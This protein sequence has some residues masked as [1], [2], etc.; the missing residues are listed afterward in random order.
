MGIYKKVPY[1]VGAVSGVYAP[2]RLKDKVIPIRHNVPGNIIIVHG[3]NDVG[4]AYAAVESGLCEGLTTRLSGDLNSAR[5]RLPTEAD[6]NRLEAD[7]DAV[8]YKRDITDDTHSPVIPFYWGFREL[9]DSVLTNTKLSRGQFLDRHGNRLDKDYSKGGGPFAN[10]TSSLP[11]MWNKGKWGVFR[12]LDRA[13]KDAT[14][15][16]LN[17]PGRM[18]MI[19][20]AR[21]LA[22]LI[23]MIRDYDEDETVSIVAHSQGCLI[24]LLAQAFLLDPQM[25]AVQANAR[26]ADTLILNNPPYSLIE[27]IPPGVSFVDGYSDDDQMMQGRYDSIDGIQTLNARLTT[28]ARITK[29][30]WSRKHAQPPLPELSDP[31]RHCGAVGKKWNSEE[32]RDNRGKVYLYF[33]PEDMT[34][35]LANVQ[36]IGWQGVP[37]YQRGTR[38]DR[39]TALGV[40]H[41]SATNILRKPLEELGEGFRQRVFTRKRRPDPQTG[42]FVQVGAA[43]SPYYFMLR[44]KGEDDQSHTEVSD[45]YLSKKA[46]RG[47]LASTSDSPAGADVDEKISHGVRLING[48]KL[49]QPVL[50]SLL[51]A[52]STDAKGRA[53]AS[54]AVDQI[55]ASIAITSEYG[56]NEMWVCIAYPFPDSEAKEL[57]IVD[58]PNRK[59]HDG[60]VGELGSLKKGKVQAMLNKDKAPEGCCDVLEAYVCLDNGFTPLPVKPIKVLVKRTET[61]DEARLRWQ[62]TIVPRSFHGAIFGGKENHRNVTA[63]DVAIGGGKASSDPNF[64]RYLCAVAD[65][66]VQKNS[67]MKRP[68]IPQWNKFQNTYSTYLSAEP[69]WRSS[70]IAGNVTYYSTGVLPS[71]LPVLPEGLPADVLSEL[72]R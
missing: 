1:Q 69:A 8:F 37:M 33:G 46:V 22:A 56:V 25:K 38:N 7:P 2:N 31:A 6:K 12:V 50:A 39:A 16:V 27:D 65:W 67:S 52:S 26:P 40:G 36:G 17:N 61:P 63:Y 42:A 54:E 66:R 24:S 14:H 51:E 59:L 49:K 28:L 71:V 60:R 45:S 43:N 53:G 19:L 23:C 34:V 9:S 21:R 64:H 5:Y 48:E 20:A 55:D 57:K 44:Q 41:N 30:I 4:T 47:H 72:K 3:V 11:D 62:H 18:Y 10:A 68:G 15:P 13:Q 58:S 29:G 35:A 32:D 70:L